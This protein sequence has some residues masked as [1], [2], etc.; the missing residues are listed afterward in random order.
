M[1]KLSFFSNSLISD[2]KFGCHPCHSSLDTILLLSQQWLQVL[3]LKHCR[4][5]HISGI[6]YS[7]VFWFAWKALC[8]WHR[9]PPSCL[10]LRLPPPT[11]SMCWHNWNPGLPLSQWRLKFLMAVFRVQCCSLSISWHL[12]VCLSHP[13]TQKTLLGEKR[14]K[15]K[16]TSN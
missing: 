14:Y 7:Q 3:N 8:L 15:V 12:S 2:H 13:E 1:Y 16:V 11:Q 4:L 5:G 10:D 6:W 9:R